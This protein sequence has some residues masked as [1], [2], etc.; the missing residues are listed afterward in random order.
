M[1]MQQALRRAIPLAL[2]VAAALAAVGCSTTTPVATLATS[3]TANKPVVIT[4]A[5][6]QQEAL[7]QLGLQNALQAYWQA[8]SQRDWAKLFTMEYPPADS[9]LSEKFYIPYHARAWP[10]LEVKVLSSKQEDDAGDVLLSQE[11]R[12]HNPDKDK[13]HLAYRHDKWHLVKG[14]WWH[15][16]NDPMLLKPQQ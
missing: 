4:Y 10:V 3:V 12:Y 15:I 14:Q 8:Y 11:V 9:P 16:V 1:T 2:S 6:G 7:E 5:E 13:P